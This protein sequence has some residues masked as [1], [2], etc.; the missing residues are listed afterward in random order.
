[1]QSLTPE[2]PLPY[3]YGFAGHSFQLSAYRAGHTLIDFVFNKPITVTLSYNND[4]VSD[5]NEGRLTLFLWKGGAWEDAACAPYTRQPGQGWLA[6]PICH[7]SEFA[8]FG[9]KKHRLYLPLITKS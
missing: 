1:M 9:M 7:L 2:N 3:G 8:L 4:D 6:A 5:L